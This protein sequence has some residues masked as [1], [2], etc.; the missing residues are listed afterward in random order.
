CLCSN[1][2]FYICRILKG[3][4]QR[5]NL[6]PDTSSEKIPANTR[7]VN[8]NLCRQ[9]FDC[10]ELFLVIVKLQRKI[11]AG[12]IIFIERVESP[13]NGCRQKTQCYGLPVS[14]IDLKYLQYRSQR[15]HG[16]STPD[17][18]LAAAFVASS[19]IA[20]LLNRIRPPRSISRR[21]VSPSS[22]AT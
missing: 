18:F 10:H 9:R 11:D 20:D 5:R 22:S 7:N 12:G 3:N 2:L 6:E 15:A 8:S 17:Y 14:A 4:N 21:K 16:R 1:Y 19:D 13:E